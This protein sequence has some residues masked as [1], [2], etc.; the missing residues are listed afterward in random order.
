MLQRTSKRVTPRLPK[1]LLVDGLVG[2]GRRPLVGRAPE[3]P[4][5]EPA[6]SLGGTIFRR[7]K[8]A[9]LFDDIWRR[10]GGGPRD[11]L[12]PTPPR[13]RPAQV[14][15][16]PARQVARDRQWQCDHTVTVTAGRL[17]AAPDPTSLLVLPPGP[18]LAATTIK[19][20]HLV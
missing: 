9:V 7:R 20:I 5:D 8:L 19:Y 1:L 14:G 10:G 4:D 15:H 2:T 17:G 13:S 16:D 18:E 6:D 11:A 12:R 3:P